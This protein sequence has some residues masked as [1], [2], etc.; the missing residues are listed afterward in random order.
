MLPWGNVEHDGT[1]MMTS[2]C[3]DV[4][5][6]PTIQDHFTNDQYQELVDPAKLEYKQRR[7]NS[8][9]FEVCSTVA[10]HTHHDGSPAPIGGWAIS[11]YDPASFQ[12]GR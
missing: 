9:F 6:T 11:S 7:E 3:D 8:I 5:D 12:R 2:L 10:S 1:G 4:I